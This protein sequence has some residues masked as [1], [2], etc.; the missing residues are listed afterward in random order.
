MK[1]KS[2]LKSGKSAEVA[3]FSL[4]K[5]QDD[6]IFRDYVYLILNPMQAFAATYLYLQSAKRTYCIMLQ[7]DT[8]GAH[9]RKTGINST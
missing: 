2:Y 3:I 7:S 8:F 9:G 1:R 5:E 4:I 6:G